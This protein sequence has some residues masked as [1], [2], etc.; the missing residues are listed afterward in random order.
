MSEEPMT[1]NHLLEHAFSDMRVHST[2]RIIQQ[3]Q[4]GVLIHSSSD[5]YPLLL[6]STQVYTLDYTELKNENGHS[7][8]EEYSLEWT[9]RKRTP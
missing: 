6:T 2:E 1:A 8:S 3:V 7:A 4:I 9:Q 5:G